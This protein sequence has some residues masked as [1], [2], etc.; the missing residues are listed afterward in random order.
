[1]IRPASHAHPQRNFLIRHHAAANLQRFHGTEADSTHSPTLTE[2]D[3]LPPSLELADD[4]G[5]PTTRKFARSMFSD[6]AAF[7]HAVEYA[8]P[9]ERFER[10]LDWLDR[11][12]VWGAIAGLACGAA[13]VVAWINK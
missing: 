5:W 13:L 7:P 8:K 6:S 2:G 11:W 12:R 9:I 1:M 4:S 3:T 10:G